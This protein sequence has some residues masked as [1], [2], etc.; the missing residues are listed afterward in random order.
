MMVQRSIQRV[1]AAVSGAILNTCRDVLAYKSDILIEGTVGITIDHDE[2]LL[3]AINSALLAETDPSR[4]PRGHT[5]QQRIRKAK[6]VTIQSILERCQKVVTYENVGHV[7]GLLGITV[8]QEEIFLI[9]INNAFP[10]D[11]VT[12]DVIV[13]PDTEE[14]KIPQ[15]G[16][17][18]VVS[19][20]ENNE[21]E[22]E[23][24]ASRPQKARRSTPF[25]HVKPI[26]SMPQKAKRN[27][28]SKT[29]IAKR[30]ATDG[31]PAK[32]RKKRDDVDEGKVGETVEEPS[33]DESMESLSGRR[34]I[35]KRRDSDYEYDYHVSDD[36]DS[37]PPT[38]NLDSAMEE[39]YDEIS[40]DLDPDYDPEGINKDKVEILEIPSDDDD[41]IMMEDEED[42]IKSVMSKTKKKTN[43]EDEGDDD[44]GIFN[45][46]TPVVVDLEL[47]KAKKLESYD[48]VPEVKTKTESSKSFLD[49]FL[50]F[51]VNKKQRKVKYIKEIKRESVESDREKTKGAND[52]ETSDATT[53]LTD[54]FNEGILDD[55]DYAV[56]DVTGHN[57]SVVTIT[58]PAPPGGS[59]I[60][61]QVK[62]S[63]TIKTGSLGAAYMPKPLK[64][65]PSH[66]PERPT[67]TKII[68]PKKLPATKSDQKKIIIMPKV[69][70]PAKPSAATVQVQ[71]PAK[72][73]VSSPQAQ[74]PA[75]LAGA[76]QQS[77]PQQVFM[78]ST[79]IPGEEKYFVLQG[80][81]QF[82]N[83]GKSTKLIIK[84]DQRVAPK[85]PVT[86]VVAAKPQGVT[87]KSQVPQEGTAK[88]EVPQG[89][90]AKS[91]VSILQSSKTLQTASPTT[92]KQKTI[93][94][95]LPSKTPGGAPRQVSILIKGQ[96]QL[97]ASGILNQ[98]RAFI[99]TSQ[100]S[101]VNSESTA[102]SIL[103]QLSQASSVSTTIQQQT[104]ASN[105]LSNVG[106]VSDQQF[107]ANTATDHMVAPLAV[108]DM[109]PE[110]PIEPQL[111]VPVV[112][113]VGQEVNISDLQMGGPGEMYVQVGPDGSITYSATPQQ[114]AAPTQ[115]PVGTVG[116]AP[117]FMSSA[118]LSL[119]LDTDLNLQVHTTYNG[120]C[121][122]VSLYLL[123]FR[124]VI[125]MKWIDSP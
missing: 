20:T 55:Q 111:E 57:P 123:S 8:D 33:L 39:D 38:E 97:T 61:G 79:G 37:E 28:A 94:V 29:E 22:V 58:K 65:K 99:N 69:I 113:S 21:D 64:P 34:R 60:L 6:S 5:Q 10:S 86:Q 85:S 48:K 36:E 4:A 45:D 104:V 2:I 26:T 121:V 95:T 47:A 31:E 84:K 54:L 77:Q 71:L 18:S 27:V 73:V 3:L 74:L 109:V 110:V 87:V 14:T 93:N 114:M 76:V 120:Y 89:G 119:P 13:V 9:N 40:D 96:S 16:K 19:N 116:D 66:T 63:K 46:D 103:S 112:P 67:M 53:T 1:K 88:S 92:Q 125:D 122:I 80:N 82:Q 108:V 90:S 75:K 17:S 12:M 51:S 98:K 44:D 101:R 118:D 117:S 30:V 43:I 42:E 49:S 78:I 59:K 124:D 23:V 52:V 24:V 56:T 83:I 81:Q 11:N 41:V 7:E 100:Q 107:V 70:A 25:K 91:R 106:V 35:K 115:S 50:G 15:K 102:A 32:K 105:Q 62:K 72:N 68:S